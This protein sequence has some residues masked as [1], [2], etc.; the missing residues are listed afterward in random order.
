MGEKFTNKVIKIA[1]SEACIRPIFTNLCCYSQ[2]AN[3]CIQYNYVHDVVTIDVFIIRN[4][5]S[6][7]HSSTVC[8]VISA[9]SEK[10]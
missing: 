10:S 1:K 4:Y 3:V 5:P 2:M 9:G 8:I 6:F 7:K